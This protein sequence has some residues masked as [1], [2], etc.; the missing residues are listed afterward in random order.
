MLMWGRNYQSLY[1]D[2]VRQYNT[3]VDRINRLGGEEFLQSTPQET[4]FSPEELNKLLRLCH[5]D[6]HKGSAKAT[7]LT[8]KILK[9]RKKA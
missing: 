2:L 8:Q 5:P 9:L 4:Q 6:K 1:S 7:E 3:L